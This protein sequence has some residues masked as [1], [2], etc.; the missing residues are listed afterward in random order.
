MVAL[1]S[2][3]PSAEPC[4]APVFCL[5]G[6]GQPMIVRSTMNDGLSGDG[7]GGLDRVVQRLDVLLVAAFGH[8]G[9]VLHVP[10]VGLVAGAD[11]LGLGDDRVV[12]DRD[13]V[14]VVDDDQ[15]AE[16]LHRGDRGRLVGDALFDV[17][18]GG[19]RVHEVV[20]RRGAGRGARVEQAPLAARRHRHADRV[21]QALAERPGGGLDAGGQPVLGVAGGDRPPGAERL[22]VVKP[23][24][25]AGQVQLDVERQRRVPARQHETVPARPLRVGRVMPHHA[26]E[27]QVG[28][29]REGHRGARVPVAHLL[30]RVHRQDPDQV[31]GPLVG[32][33]PVKGVVAH[34]YVT[35]PFCRLL[36]R[37]PRLSGKAGV[38]G[39]TRA[40]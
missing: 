9:D 11:V 6:A 34:L 10:A 21:A 30:H 8:P 16:F 17:A 15:V 23:D 31:N 38:R 7:L 28:G 35:D 22:Q 1:T 20:E 2:A 36:W 5:F 12:L 32:G 37:P 39:G 25:V 14:V 24:P 13:V 18:V 29:G 27:Q 40:G 33:C 19:D 4:A 26:L 3:S